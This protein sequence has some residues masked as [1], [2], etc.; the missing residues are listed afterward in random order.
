MNQQGGLARSVSTLLLKSAR[1][2]WVGSVNALRLTMRE[3]DGGESVRFL[4]VSNAS[5]DSIF[6][7]CPRPT[8]PPLTQA[9]RRRKTNSCGLSSASVELLQSSRTHCAAQ[10]K[11]KCI[12]R[13]FGVAECASW[14]VMSF[15]ARPAIAAR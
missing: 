2:L 12:S 11:M 3:A 9:V 4:A 5:A 6:E 7:P 13:Y 15:L 10:M 14:Q 8:H 1:R